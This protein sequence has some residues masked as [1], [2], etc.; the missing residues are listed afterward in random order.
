MNNYMNLPKKYYPPSE[1]MEYYD[2]VEDKYYDVNGD[3]L[4]SPAEYDPYGEGY[5]PFGDE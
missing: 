4:R 2:V 1:S 3:E 5:T